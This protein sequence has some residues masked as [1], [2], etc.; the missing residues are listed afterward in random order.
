[1][2]SPPTAI[3]ARI[4]LAA[5][6]CLAL[7]FLSAAPRDSTRDSS[8]CA[9]RFPS[10]SSA[11]PGG[12]HGSPTALGF[13]RLAFWGAPAAQA[14]E[15]P[16]E[17]ANDGGKR[18]R[19]GFVT[20]NI[21]KDWDLSTII[22]KCKATGFEGVELRTTH[23][24]GVEIT[25]TPA[26]R[27][28]VRKQFE[29]SG[30]VLAGL[31]TACEYHNPDQAEVRRNIEETKEWVKLAA[32]LG[33]PG[34]KVRP[35]GL[36]EGVPVEKT[37]EQIG[38]ALR[39][40]GE[41]AQQYGVQ[42]RLEVHGGGTSLVP[43]VRKILDYANQPNVW[44][45]W[46]SNDNDLAGDGLQANFDLVAG[47]IG[48]VHMRDLYIENY[49]WRELFSLLKKSGYTGF[50]LAEIQASADPERVLKYYRALWL[51]LQR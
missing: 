8:S 13:A 22:E 38:L 18:M 44:A 31:G 47:R 42:I 20:Y 16:Q 15:Q 23:A 27:A 5:A 33:C 30:I 10:L 21:A 50:C 19:L 43:N 2:T 12:W 11:Q 7:L 25:L 34:V 17:T 39:E 26:E 3:R 37:L 9:P 41:F 24:H 14:D 4:L 46:N 28:A 48:L 35:N 45:C 36:P 51:E 1:M 40:C 32:D 49:P 6:P 29:D